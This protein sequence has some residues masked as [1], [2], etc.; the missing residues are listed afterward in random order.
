V[1][2]EHQPNDTVA[3]RR[4]HRRSFYNVERLSTMLSR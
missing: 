4:G 3:V 2:D 1:G